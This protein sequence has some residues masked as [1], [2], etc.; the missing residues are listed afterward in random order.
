MNNDD[1]QSNQNNFI[2]FSSMFEKLNT[3]L[4]ENY[5][6]K[7]KFKKYANLSKIF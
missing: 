4:E 7:N 5:K 6:N 2:N 1:Y 3:T